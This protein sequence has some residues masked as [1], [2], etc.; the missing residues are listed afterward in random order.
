MCAAPSSIVMLPNMSIQATR[1]G[2]SGG[3]PVHHHALRRDFLVA[4][5]DPQRNV[6]HE[7]APA[8][9]PAV[10][11]VLGVAAD[12]DPNPFSFHGHLAVRHNNLY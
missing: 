7:A 11:D 4:V 12:A 1:M 9:F 2:L 3:G 8:V 5:E 10:L 6:A